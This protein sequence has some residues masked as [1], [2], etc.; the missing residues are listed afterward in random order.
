MDHSAWSD[1]DLHS[2]AFSGGAWERSTQ[3]HLQE[4]HAFSS[5]VKVCLHVVQMDL[6]VGFLSSFSRMGD[7]TARESNPAL[8]PP[9]PVTSGAAHDEA[10]R[11]QEGDAAADGEGVGGLL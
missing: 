11:R 5:G 3:T 4:S 1:L 8:P 6:D 9:P 2:Q 7:S 10:E